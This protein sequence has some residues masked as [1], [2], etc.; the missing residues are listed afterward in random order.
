MENNMKKHICMIESFCCIPETNTILYINY[1]LIKKSTLALGP[2][3][4]GF[5]SHL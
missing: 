5:L 4:P 1:T 3:L 2:Q